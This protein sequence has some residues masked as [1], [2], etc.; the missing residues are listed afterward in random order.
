M[1]KKAIISVILVATITI[2]SALLSFGPIKETFAGE[3]KRSLPVYSVERSDKKI[4]ITFDCAWGVEHTDEIINAVNEYGV[5]CTFFAV[6]FWIEKYPEYVKK[7]DE[8]GIEIGTH[9]ATHSHMSKMS[10]DEIKKELLSSSAAIENITGKK[11]TLFRAPFGEYDNEVINTAA[12]S[13]YKTIQ[14]DVDSLDWKDLN[15][16]E[17]A[18]RVIK[19]VKSG[20]IILCHNNGKH[21]AQALPLIFTALKERGFEFVTVG[22]LLLEGKTTIDN[23]GR[24]RPI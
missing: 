4:S 24:Q 6:E 3:V 18:A 14:W 23:N 7:L 10:A 9:S 19:R 17:I 15:A 8:N 5:K 13:G 1:R 22:E 2:I 21:T 12:A 16:E 20:S 11:V